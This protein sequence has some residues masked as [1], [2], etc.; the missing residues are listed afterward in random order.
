MGE[1]SV[2]VLW[3]LD[4]VLGIIY[5]KIKIENAVDYSCSNLNVGLDTYMLPECPGPII[6]VNRISLYSALLLRIG[7]YKGQSMWNL[8]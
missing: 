6:I 5:G 3:S 7:V 8:Y 4:V 2:C 1:N